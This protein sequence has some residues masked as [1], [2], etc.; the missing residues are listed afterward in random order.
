MTSLWDQ[1]LRRAIHSHIISQVA[2]WPVKPLNHG[3]FPKF[4]K[5][6]TGILLFH[7]L[8]GDYYEK[9][10]FR[11]SV[12]LLSLTIHK[13]VSS[14][15][16][17]TNTVQSSSNELK[18]LRQVIFLYVVLVFTPKLQKKQMHNPAVQTD[19]ALQHC[20]LGPCIASHHCSSPSNKC[21]Y[22]Q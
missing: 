15:I 1:I 8:T 7:G 20:I 21:K 14:L 19:V 10:T 4:N 17:I 2:L 12:D 11:V 3:Y 22:F 13:C 9:V 6:A 18:W 16:V 5:M